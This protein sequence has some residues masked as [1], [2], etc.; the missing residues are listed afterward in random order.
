MLTIKKVAAL[1]AAVNIDHVA[2]K[3]MFTP[4]LV[5]RKGG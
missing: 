1:P 5:V 4:V 2:V 3:L